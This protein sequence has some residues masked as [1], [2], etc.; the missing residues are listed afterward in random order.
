MNEVPRIEV[1]WQIIVAFIALFALNLLL[2]YL[3]RQNC[4]ERVE[5]AKRQERRDTMAN[6]RNT[7]LCA[8]RH[9]KHD[10]KQET[11]PDA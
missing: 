9:A 7:Y 4:D 6:Y 5:A 1:P 3:K 11:T 8:M 10:S 2:N